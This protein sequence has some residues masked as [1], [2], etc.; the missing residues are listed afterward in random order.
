MICPHAAGDCV[1]VFLELCNRR[2]HIREQAH[3][4]SAA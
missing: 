4:G 2:A 3:A 1:T